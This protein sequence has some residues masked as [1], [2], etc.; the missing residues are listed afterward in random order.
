MG[1]LVT[2]VGTPNAAGL[3]PE[4]VALARQSTHHKHHKTR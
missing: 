1:M 3:V 2:G 4:L